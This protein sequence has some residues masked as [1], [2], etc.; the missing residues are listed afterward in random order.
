MNK[1]LLVNGSPRPHGNTAILAE[2]LAEGV[3]SAGGT[4]DLASMAN[5]K[6]SHPGCSACMG[7][8]QPANR[9]KCVLGD[10]LAQLVESVPNYDVLVF[11]FPVYFFHPN[12]Q[13]KMFLDRM[14]CLFDAKTNTSI[15]PKIKIAILASAGGGL[16][17]GLE[18]SDNFFISLARFLK[19]PYTSFLKPLCPED[20]K[21]LK[22]DTKTLEDSKNFGQHLAQ[23]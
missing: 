19:T 8:Q 10:D 16:A 11:A 15:I 1:I 13:I 3:R 22:N 7:C 17:G 12:A 23:W 6:L 9:G 21:R 18:A 14:F 2:A 20:S 5:L 4:I